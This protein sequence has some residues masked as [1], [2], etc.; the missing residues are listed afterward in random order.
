MA[1]GDHSL[2]LIG[3]YSIKTILLIRRCS[4]CTTRL[5]AVFFHQIPPALR[6]PHHRHTCGEKSPPPHA[7]S[8]ARSVSKLSYEGTS[9]DT[10]SE[11]RP[12]LQGRQRTSR[13]FL[14]LFLL[15]V[16]G[17]ERTEA[18]PHCDA[19]ASITGCQLPV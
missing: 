2:V 15:L 5:F 8:P 14:P 11:K 4:I 18:I 17:Q 19:S 16:P 7:R 12:L 10:R 13:R 3:L 9:E 6:F 1:I